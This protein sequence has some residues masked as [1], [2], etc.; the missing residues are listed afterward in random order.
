MFSYLKNCKQR[1]VIN[2]NPTITKTVVAG[3]SQ[4]SID[5]PLLFNIF[6]KRSS[7]I[8]TIYDTRQL[9]WWQSSIY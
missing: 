3:V 6:I 1:V 5:G 2:V 9:R 7:F 8:Y 4:G